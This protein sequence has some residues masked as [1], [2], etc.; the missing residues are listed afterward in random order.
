MTTFLGID[1][2]KSG[3][4]A[5]LAAT[6]TVHDLPHLDGELD[7]QSLYALLEPHKGAVVVLE[8]QQAVARSVKRKDGTW[9]T[10]ASASGAFEIGKG[11]GGV[12]AC[13]RLAGLVIHRV[14]PASWKSALGLSKDKALSLRK[15]RDLFP[16]LAAELR[17]AGD[18]GRAEALLLAVYG[19]DR[20]AAGGA[21]RKRAAPVFVERPVEVDPAVAALARRFG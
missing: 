17:R 14:T 13:C 5:I 21:T 3:A 15:A 12:L 20:L 11:Y 9:T 8:T 7:Y 19:R 18:D 10:T 2:G 16:E 4:L 1:P 6:S